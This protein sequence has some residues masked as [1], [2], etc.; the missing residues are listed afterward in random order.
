MNLAR[1]KSSVTACA[2]GS[3]AQIFSAPASTT[4]APQSAV[5]PH[6]APSAASNLLV[7]RKAASLT[8]LSWLGIIEHEPLLT[9]SRH[10]IED[11][12]KARIRATGSRLFDVRRGVSRAR[13]PRE[14]ASRAGESDVAG[15]HPYLGVCAQAAGREWDATT[16]AETSRN[17]CN[18]KQEKRNHRC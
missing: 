11:L 9:T 3:I 1:Q 2:A 17:G 4:P 14:F 15:D 8:R 13:R 6:T 18:F 10:W 7:M 12:L 5:P 16:A